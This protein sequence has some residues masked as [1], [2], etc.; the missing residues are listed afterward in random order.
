MINCGG[1]LGSIGY[2]EDVAGK[3][4]FKEYTS[5]DF[6][7]YGTRKKRREQHSPTSA[8]YINEDGKRAEGTGKHNGSEKYSDRV[9]QTDSDYRSAVERG[10]MK[11]AQKMVDEAA[12]T[13]GFTSPKPYHGTKSYGFTE[14]DFVLKTKP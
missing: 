4:L 10:D 7:D 3:R 9:A 11:T 8:T 13:A 14:F 1:E 5:A 12:K 6:E 2:L